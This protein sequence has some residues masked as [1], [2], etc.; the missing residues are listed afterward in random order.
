[1]VHIEFGTETFVYHF[2]KTS[3][4]EILSVN[5]VYEEILRSTNEIEANKKI[6]H[7]W[8]EHNPNLKWLLEMGAFACEEDG[9]LS[10][11][12]HYKQ[13]KR[14]IFDQIAPDVSCDEDEENEE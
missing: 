2:I 12:E 11:G 8:I 14:M 5:A 10:K 6:P 1:M 7:I 9:T 13:I 3:S 4:G